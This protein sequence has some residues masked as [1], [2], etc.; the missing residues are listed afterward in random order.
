M[1]LLLSLCTCAHAPLY[2]QCIGPTDQEVV[3]N[4]NSVSLAWTG[5]S[6]DVLRQEYVISFCALED[7][8]TE[9]IFSL[10][11]AGS[12]INLF[13]FT[14]GTTFFAY[15]RN[16]CAADTGNGSE[17]AS[18]WS[19]FTF[20]TQG[21]V[22]PFNNDDLANPLTL[23]SNFSNNVEGEEVASTS[24]EPNERICGFANS[25]WY[26]FTPTATQAYT[27]SSGDVSATAVTTDT[28]VSLGIYTGSTHPLT[29][30]VCQNANNHLSGGETL[31]VTL[32][33][34]TTYYFRV[35]MASGAR[36]CRI[37]TSIEIIPFEWEGSISNDWFT[38]DNWST[39]EV[40]VA[41]QAISFPVDAVR[42]CVIAS[43][44]AMAG[45]IDLDGG[46]LTVAQGAF[47]TVSAATSGIVVM[48]GGTFEVA[49]AVI[50]DAP[51]GTGLSVREGAAHIRATGLVSA[52]DGARTLSVS[53]T[54]SIAGQ[55][56]GTGAVFDALRV[57]TD[58]ALD[59]TEGGLITVAG[60]DE[61][62][63]RCAGNCW[64]NGTLM[65][66]DVGDNGIDT[67]DGFLTV[68]ATGSVAL[69]TV[70]RGIDNGNFN[71]HGSI[72]VI[73]T[74]SDAINTAGDCANYGS[75][76]LS[77]VD[78]DGVDLEEGST[79]TNAGTVRVLDASSQALEDGVFDQ[80]ASGALFVAGE[81]TSDIQLAVGSELH[82]GSSP[83]C[84][85][86]TTLS[87]LAGVELYVEL[88]GP[89][90]CVEYDQLQLGDHAVDL[91]DAELVLSGDYFPADGDVF[92][93]LQRSSSSSVSGTFA[94][95]PE[96]AIIVFNNS[97]LQINYNNG[98]GVTLTAVAVLPLDL[99]SF[100]GEAREKT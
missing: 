98:S 61:S 56:F 47:L 57:R 3:F 59:L 83:G 73:N 68:G 52:F 87:N 75:I 90:A 55:L 21:D 12:F 15:V 23:T 28:D 14:T 41:G 95:L 84:V 1:L 72:S 65:V 78:S 74:N 60:A 6:T 97:L 36:P 24:V 4:P 42:A 25:W 16:I 80:T 29:E 92:V 91:T 34:G 2:A 45:G 43:G 67:E 26:A 100:T 64:I 86:S 9:T 19:T 39:G 46:S 69:N 51:S 76:T 40:P 48:D 30:V 89:T 7:P 35:A 63:L 71:N 31:D 96:E 82:P 79:F 53:D 93:I 32:T 10:N 49:G 13:G 85:E 77:N 70:N 54:M 66:S 94:G 58:G 33:A 37:L 17:V 11:G 22:V 62:G 44:N 99:L 27:I 88:E 8:A 5:G 38:A 18:D 50:I 81:I 20:T